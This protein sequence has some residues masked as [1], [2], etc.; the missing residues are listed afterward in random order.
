MDMKGFLQLRS[1]KAGFFFPFTFSFPAVS[2]HAIDELTGVIEGLPSRQQTGIS[3][4]RRSRGP[5]QNKTTCHWTT[6]HRTVQENKR[7]RKKKNV[8]HWVFADRRRLITAVRGQPLYDV[9]FV[10][11]EME[12]QNS[13]TASSSWFSRVSSGLYVDKTDGAGMETN[14]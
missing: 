1:S 6:T 8:Q 11:F 13:S 12:I 2:S 7:K 5:F 3:G 9:L 10:F 4:V 14:L